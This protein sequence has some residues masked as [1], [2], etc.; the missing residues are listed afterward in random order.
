MAATIRCD[1]DMR[2]GQCP[3]LVAHAFVGTET[4]MQHQHRR[5]SAVRLVINRNVA[6]IE[7]VAAVRLAGS[8]FP[9]V[10]GEPPMRG[11]I[12]HIDC[13]T[14]RRDKPCNADQRKSS[15]CSH[16][17]RPDLAMKAPAVA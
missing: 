13:R 7:M 8:Q 16:L 17:E 14:Q 11:S 3:D 9:G 2:L 5:S 12:A 15:G 10:E 1:N 6:S 4:A